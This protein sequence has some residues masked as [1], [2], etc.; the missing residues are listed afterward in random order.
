MEIIPE[1]GCW[2]QYEGLKLP[3]LVFDPRYNSNSFTGGIYEDKKPELREGLSFCKIMRLVSED[4]AKRLINGRGMSRGYSFQVNET[5]LRANAR[6][7]NRRR[8][9]Y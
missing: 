4:E 5:T 1:I 8:P 9:R 6:E 7:E 2:V 3:V